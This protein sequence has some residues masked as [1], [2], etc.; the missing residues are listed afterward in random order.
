MHQNNRLRLCA[1]PECSGTVPPDAK[2]CAG[3]WD[4]DDPCASSNRVVIYVHYD[5]KG[6]VHDYVYHGVE[7]FAAAGL[8]VHFVSNAKCLPRD[9]IRTGAI[10]RTD[11]QAQECGS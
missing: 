2:L 6:C 7:Q 1:R 11:L 3:A 10:L 8:R 5:K 4:G 9:A